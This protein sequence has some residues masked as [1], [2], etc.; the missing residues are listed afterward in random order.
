MQARGKARDRSDRAFVS[1]SRLHHRATL[2]SERCR[3]RGARRG[4]D[5]RR[6]GVGCRRRHAGRRADEHFAF[7]RLF[8]DR[9]ERP[10]RRRQTVPRRSRPD[11]G[12]RGIA[13]VTSSAST[14]AAARFS[15]G[16]SS[17]AGHGG[18]LDKGTSKLAQGNVAYTALV[19]V[20]KYTQTPPNV[21]AFDPP[22]TAS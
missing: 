9:S 18:D 11:G 5:R 6:C 19:Q 14:A 22:K 20:E 13:V 12:E 17:G 2:V 8:T 21:M 4:P 7:W 3:H 1:R 16:P 10:L 15:P